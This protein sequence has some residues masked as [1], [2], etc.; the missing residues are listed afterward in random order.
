MTEMADYGTP[1]SQ[2]LLHS[3]FKNLVNQF[4]KILPIKENGE[5]TLPVYMESLMAEL[6]GCKSL[7]P[8]LN[9]NAQYMAL[10]SILQFLIDNQECSVKEVKREVF[11]AI[12]IC[13][14]LESAYADHG[15]EVAQ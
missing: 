15:P 10:L 1:V 8:Q 3:Y 11:K 14:K 2:E 4:F 7:V 12:N 9:D 6:L 5:D 13:N